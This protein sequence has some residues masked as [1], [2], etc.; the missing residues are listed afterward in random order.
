MGKSHV[1]N[2]GAEV[3]VL[4]T[5]S[6]RWF[7]GVPLTYGA[8][9]RVEG[10]MTLSPHFL[11]DGSVGAQHLHYNAARYGSYTGPVIS[12]NSTLT[13]APDFESSVR[14]NV[15]YARDLTAVSAFRNSQNAGGLGYYRENLPLKFAVYGGVQAAFIKYDALLGAF[16]AIRSDVAMDYWVTLSNTQFTI[17]GF[18]LTLS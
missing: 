10:R 2:S 8:G 4:G 16:G 6:R 13:Y 1:D 14:A 5:A 11:L 9:G 3:S 12:T 7:G 17:G 18:T 15:G